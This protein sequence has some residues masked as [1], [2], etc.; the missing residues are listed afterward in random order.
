MNPHVETVHRARR[1]AVIGLALGLLMLG[2]PGVVLAT[3]P[4]R[5]FLEICKT[6]AGPGVTGTFQFSVAGVTVPVPVGACSAPVEVPA[7]AVTVTEEFQ[8]GLVVAG[9][10]TSPS[11][12]LISRNLASRSV[13]V[14]VVEGDAPTQ[15]VVTFANTTEWG[16]LKV[17]KVAGPG[18]AEGTNFVFLAGERA[19]NVLAG[20]APGGFCTPA[21]YFLVGTGVTVAESVP[22]GVQVTD[23]AVSPPARATGSPDLAAG[24][25]AVAI[26]TGVTEVVFTNASAPTSSTTT[27]TTPPGG[28]TTTTVS[29]GS[30]TTTSTPPGGSPP[31]TVG[32]PGVASPP[33]GGPVGRGRTTS[34]LALTGATAWGLL[35]WATLAA[36]AGVALVMMGRR[37]QGMAALAGSSPITLRGGP[38]AHR[39]RRHPRPQPPEGGPPKIRPPDI[40]PGL[41]G[42]GVDAAPEAFDEV[43]ELDF[44]NLEWV[45]ADLPPAA[46]EAR[47]DPAG[48]GGQALYDPVGRRFARATGRGGAVVSPRRWP[49]SAGRRAPRR[50]ALV[51]A[52][53]DQ[54]R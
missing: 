42:P 51:S 11:A 38:L 18:V 47:P 36:L 20:P 16:Q 3:I 25:V 29:G 1:S 9:I 5:G 31:T 34:S 35:P 37:P 40:G 39:P 23:V 44:D 52:P 49:A 10:S 28:A 43:T 24:R 50:P 48:G 4:G 15:T 26:G 27:T 46:P 32:G 14:T 19:V 13:T 12:R 8:P 45:L 22:H 7:G 33:T 53:P 6:A 41:P 30:P 17:C 54:G 2:V 21:G